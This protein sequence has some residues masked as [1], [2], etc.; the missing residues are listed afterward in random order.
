MNKTILVN[1]EHLRIPMGR[2]GKAR[3]RKKRRPKPIDVNTSTVKKK[4]MNKIKKYQKEQLNKSNPM[5]KYT[6]KVKNKNPNKPPPPPPPP[7]PTADTIQNKIKFNNEFKESFDYLQKI[8]DEK[9]R[10]E[11]NKKRELKK[12][13]REREREKQQDPMVPNQQ[14]HKPQ[15]KEAVSR[16]G[17][18]K[19]G[20]HF[21]PKKEPAYGILKGGKK[22][23]YSTYKNRTLKQRSF[24]GLPS[25]ETENPS[26]VDRP[27]PSPLPPLPPT[28]MAKMSDDTP[29]FLDTDAFKKPVIAAE[30]KSPFDFH[31]RKVKSLRERFE[32]LKRKQND[33]E[34]SNT[35]EGENSIGCS[36]GGEGVLAP[37]AAAAPANG[38]AANGAASTMASSTMAA[39]TTQ[40]PIVSTTEPLKRRR[41]RRKKRRRTRGR[42]K[43]TK[44]V[45]RRITRKYILG[46]HYDKNR[47]KSHKIA[48]L[49]PS[50]KIKKEIK[51]YIIDLS[52]KPI[53]EIK[54]HLKQQNLISVGS[55]APESLLRDIYK[56][57]Q[58][59]GEVENHDAER[60]LHHFISDENNISE[61]AI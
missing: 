61:H 24:S 58:L 10:N 1:P 38:V 2:S 59:A 6:H 43:N 12:M 33:A 52:G 55:C 5:Y 27:P 4:L 13:K 30:S 49:L 50:E 51:D 26:I 41:R 25:L 57:A 48:I 40:A 56:N 46:R 21:K 60:L 19:H 9:K 44:K 11:K 36:E 17:T 23:L 34:D 7:P 53:D 15:N 28:P 35:N 45:L 37:A 16:R 42:K 20:G 8:V 47:P 22:M 18:R 3:T 29:V 32:E 39:S 14:K 54:Q 31:K